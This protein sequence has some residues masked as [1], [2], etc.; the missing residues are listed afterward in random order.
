MSNEEIPCHTGNLF[1]SLFVYVTMPE[2][3]AHAVGPAAAAV[4]P[5]DEE[6]FNVA[7]VI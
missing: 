2:P 7:N 3:A 1:A 4:A 5:P 6:A